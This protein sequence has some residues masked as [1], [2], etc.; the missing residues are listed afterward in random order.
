MARKNLGESIIRNFLQRREIIKTGE[1][2]PG[3]WQP[4]LREIR[5]CYLSSILVE[6]TG[7]AGNDSHPFAKLFNIPSGAIVP[8]DF[9]DERHFRNNSGLSVGGGGPSHLRA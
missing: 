4:T 1:R 9:K 8:R 3:R 7:T 5:G 2:R 6:V